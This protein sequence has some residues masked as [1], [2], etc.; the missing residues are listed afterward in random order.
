MHPPGHPM[1]AM[2]LRTAKKNALYLYTLICAFSS[3]FFLNGN[4]NNCGL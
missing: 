3:V 4:H 1:A 2:M